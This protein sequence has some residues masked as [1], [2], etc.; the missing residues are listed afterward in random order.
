M[1]K[2]ASTEPGTAQ[3]L[4]SPVFVIQNT[5][6]AKKSNLCQYLQS[7]AR[8]SGGLS[9]TIKRIYFLAQINIDFNIN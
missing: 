8:E 6:G 3:S 1:A 7:I 2:T 4:N 9:P 5:S